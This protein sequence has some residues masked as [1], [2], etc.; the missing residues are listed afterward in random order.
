MGSAHTPLPRRLSHG[1]ADP[2]DMVE[3]AEMSEREELERFKRAFLAQQEEL[4]QKC[5]EVNEKTFQLETAL[6]SERYLQGKLE[7]CK[8]MLRDR[9]IRIKELKLRV[10]ARAASSLVPP[11][12]HHAG[13]LGEAEQAEGGSAFIYE[14][15]AADTHP[16]DL[17][18][19]V[20]SLSPAV[21]NTRSKRA[22]TGLEPA[23]THAIAND[24]VHQSPV[25]TR[26]MASGAVDGET[27]DDVQQRAR[28]EFIA[29]L[30]K[31]VGPAND[32]TKEFRRR[33]DFSV[34]EK[35]NVAK[36][37]LKQ[38][39]R[40]RRDGK[41][42]LSWE[43]ILGDPAYQ[44]HCKRMATNIKDCVSLAHRCCAPPWGRAPPALPALALRGAAWPLPL[45]RPHAR[46]PQPSTLSPA[47]R[48]HR[49]PAGS[50]PRA[51]CRPQF[52]TLLKT[53]YENDEELLRADH[54]RFARIIQHAE[55]AR[56]LVRQ[57][58]AQGDEQGHEGETDPSIVDMDESEP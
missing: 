11:G 21:R 49:A 44:F 8:G 40:R 22:R 41:G 17:D 3:P 45:A 42:R 34:G 30:P 31:R 33:I 52:R 26:P 28:Q 7:E 4:A 25:M 24:H 19:E 58:Q 43:A 51:P 37:W 12:Q 5:K 13:G 18:R 10:R 54:P 1:A 53:C 56:G 6:K 46:A 48:P 38:D 20:T 23:P 16:L 32:L 27:D 36:G 15:P 57:P 14:E 39:E 47:S 2:T 9:D 55:E 29:E 50:C 35:I